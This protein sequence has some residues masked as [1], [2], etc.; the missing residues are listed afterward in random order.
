MPSDDPAELERMLNRFRRL[1]SELHNGAIHRNHFEPWEIAIL[2][3]LES[4]GAKPRQWAE[5]LRH[6]AKA[7]ERQLEGGSGPPMKLSE[8]LELRSRKRTGRA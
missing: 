4:G 6:Y 7:V 1:M 5:T 3:D 2:L 8:Y